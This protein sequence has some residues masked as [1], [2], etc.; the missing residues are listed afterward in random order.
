MD[1]MTEIPGETME[2]EYSLQALTSE[3][4]S[5]TILRRLSQPI[6]EN[7]SVEYYEI[8]FTGISMLLRPAAIIWN[9]LLAVEYYNLNKWNYFTWTLSYI[10]VPMVITTLL[11]IHM[12]VDGI[13]KLPG[14]VSNIKLTSFV[15]TFP[16]ERRKIRKF[17]QSFCGWWFCARFCFGLYC[18]WYFQCLANCCAVGV[19]LS[20]FACAL[21][22]SHPWN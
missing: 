12:W 5:N 16:I 6:S 3:P 13:E 2:K 9:L 14:F 7:F 22:K 1:K 18:L 11:G 10:L 17:V 21:N 15:G 4:D 20:L 19:G 8:V